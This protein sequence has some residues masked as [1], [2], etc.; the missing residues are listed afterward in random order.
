MIE[1]EGDSLN[2]LKALLREL[3]RKELLKAHMPS[4]CMNSAPQHGKHYDLRK[5]IY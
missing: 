1:P 2:A 4:K 3:M 5:V